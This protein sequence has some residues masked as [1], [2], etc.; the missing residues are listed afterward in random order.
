M[1]GLARPIDQPRPGPMSPSTLCRFHDA[2]AAVEFAGSSYLSNHM[3]IRSEVRVGAFVFLGL[4]MMAALIFLIGDAR[5]IFE[6]KATYYAQFQDVEG[7][8]PGAMVQMGGVN[9]GEVKAVSYPEDPRISRI[10]VELSIVRSEARRIRAD[11]TISI[12]P[13]GLLGDKLLN[14]AVGDPDEP[15]LPEGA[16]IPTKEGG[17]MFAQVEEMGEKAGAVLSNLEKASSTLAE[18]GFREDVRQSASAVRGFLQKAESGEGYIPRL[19]TDQ[20]E[21]ERLSQV[22]QNLEKTTRRFDQVLRGVE[23]AVARVNRG[24]GLAHE[25]IYGEDGSKAAEQIGQ[26][27]EEM[28]LTLK[29]IREGD[30]FA[31]D[32]LFGGE[33]A[34]TTA[35]ILRNVAA[36]SSDLKGISGQV[37]EGKGTLGALLNDPSVYEDLKVLLGNVQRNEV[38]RAL[39]RYSIQADEQRGVKPP[40]P[41]PMTGASQAEVGS[42]R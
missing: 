13:K 21:A 38:L 5:R 11:S 29:G 25:V 3:A 8:I 23:D 28:A 33:D 10:R 16:V 19:L 35:E 42:T 2:F 22:I 37:R 20:Q 1:W 9:V 24:P 34:E 18:D 32:L 36:I 15:A 40:S 26:A 39:V 30:G 4:V 27:A 41:P 7:L 12:S 31:H 17:G 14:L 6:T